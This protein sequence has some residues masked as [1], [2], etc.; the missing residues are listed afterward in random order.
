MDLADV[1]GLPNLITV[2]T[3]VIADYRCS[4]IIVALTNSTHS[5][6]PSGD[7]EL[8]LSDHNSFTR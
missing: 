3:R 2:P 5:F 4:L 1:Y 8:G 6:V 7:F